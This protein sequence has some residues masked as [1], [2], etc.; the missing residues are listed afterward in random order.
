MY[1]VVAVRLIGLMECFRVWRVATQAR[2]VQ[3][4]ALTTAL[5]A[6]SGQR[7]GQH[8]D[9]HIGVCI[10]VGNL[11]KLFDTQIRATHLASCVAP[12]TLCARPRTASIPVVIFSIVFK[13]PPFK[14]TSNRPADAS[15][16][17]LHKLRGWL[18]YRTV[19]A[20]NRPIMKFLELSQLARSVQ[21]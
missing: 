21:W 6:F 2:C 16:D 7:P 13:I 1:A 17:F 12:G 18:P 10:L 11:L 14:L 5:I 9:G 8:V 3:T 4:S 19:S 20:L 15:D